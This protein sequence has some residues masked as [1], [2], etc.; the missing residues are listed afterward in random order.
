MNVYVLIPKDD[1]IKF[2]INTGIKARC[3]GRMDPWDRNPSPWMLDPQSSS[4]LRVGVVYDGIEVATIEEDGVRATVKGHCLRLHR[5]DESS[6]LHERRLCKD[7]F[8]HVMG[9]V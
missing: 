1:R 7:A 5:M 6:R 2:R 9:F 4:E 3:M 8:Q